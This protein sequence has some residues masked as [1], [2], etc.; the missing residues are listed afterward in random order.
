MI[1]QKLIF[2]SW[3]KSSLPL[4]VHLRS[5]G[6]SIKC[7]KKEFLRIDQIDDFIQVI[8]DSNPDISE[9]PKSELIP[10][11]DIRADCAFINNSVHVKV[12]NICFMSMEL[13][14]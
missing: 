8:E 9:L 12:Q 10:K 2:L 3:L 6:D 7:H 13:G 11:N 14:A 1:V 4:L 5:G